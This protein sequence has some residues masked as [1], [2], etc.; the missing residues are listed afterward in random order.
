MAKLNTVRTSILT[1]G[2]PL[3]PSMD[4]HLQL[5][6]TTIL[7]MFSVSTK[8]RSFKGFNTFFIICIVKHGINFFV[9]GNIFGRKKRAVPGFEPTTTTS[10]PPSLGRFQISGKSRRRKSKSKSRQKS[11]TTTTT[12]APVSLKTASKTPAIT[13]T[14]TPKP[15]TPKGKVNQIVSQLEQSIAERF[16]Q[17]SEETP[18]VSKPLFCEISVASLCVL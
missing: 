11:S 9:S 4:R 2:T 3:E 16:T 8:L 14:T 17:P 10:A 12:P 6:S 13:T 15:T 18:K 5:V 7:L 1:W